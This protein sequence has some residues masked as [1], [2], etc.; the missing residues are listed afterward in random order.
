M[1]ISDIFR[2]QLLLAGFSALLGA[3]ITLFTT[4]LLAK[5]AQIRYST[6]SERVGVAADDP[7]FGDVRVSWRGNE[8]RSLHMVTAEIE[9]AS[10]RDFEN[11]SFKVYVASETILLNEQTSIVGSP[12]IVSWSDEF[13]A[14]IHVP[15][16]AMPTDEQWRTY[17]H[18]R[19]YLL[20]VFNR[21]QLLHLNYLCTRPNDDVVPY[22]F[23]DLQLKGA[24]L[25]HE[26]RA[27]FVVGVPAQAASLRGL[28]ITV[29]AVGILGAFG[30]NS[31]V[32]SAVAA[33]IGLVAQLL[34]ALEYKAERWL[35][36]LIAG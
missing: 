16:G 10:N 23:V 3:I 31:L 30:H 35:R 9:N 13:K 36:E 29:V 19:K 2:N 6:R 18:T 21:G 20:P 11:V 27:N 33:V 28:F 17:N 26:F 8:V 12:N 7:V 32:V 14:E 4:R 15:P 22:V 34:G 1:D 24:K 25:K 5:T